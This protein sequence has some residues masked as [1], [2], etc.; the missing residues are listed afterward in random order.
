MDLLSA[1]I[2]PRIHSQL[3][4][5]IVLLEDQSMPINQQQTTD[6]LLCITM[7][8]S[9][10]SA[11]LTRGHHNITTFTGSMAVTQFIAVDPET[12]HIIAVSDPRKDGRP[13]GN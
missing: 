13:A 3:L 11:L 1:V 5:D 12:H 6:N 7:P 4:P 2:A 9:V 8:D 10:Y